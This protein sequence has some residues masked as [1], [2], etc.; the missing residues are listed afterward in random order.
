MAVLLWL[1]WLV[2]TDLIRPR[3]TFVPID[4]TLR[5][6]IVVHCC[7]CSD[8]GIHL[9]HSLFI[10]EYDCWYIDDTLSQVP[11][12][13]R[14]FDHHSECCPVLEATLFWLRCLCWWYD[15]HSLLTLWKYS[16]SILFF[17]CAWHCCILT[18]H[19]LWLTSHC[20]IL[21]YDVFV[22][23]SMLFST[24]DGDE[25][26]ILVILY[27]F[28]FQWPDGEAIVMQWPL[29]KLMQAHLS[30]IH[31]VVVLLW[32]SWHSERVLYSDSVF[33]WPLYLFNIV[34]DCIRCIRYS[35]H[36]SVFDILMMRLIR[37]DD[38]RYSMMTIDIIRYIRWLSMV[39]VYILT[40]MHC[41]DW[42]IVTFIDAAADLFTVS[43]H[44]LCDC[45][46]W[47]H[48]LTVTRYH[49]LIF[50]WPDF[51]VP[52]D[53]VQLMLTIVGSV[54]LFPFE[55]FIHS[56]GIHWCWWRGD[57]FLHWHCS[58]LYLFSDGDW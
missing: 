34:T 7:C 12:H 16:I 24:G 2:L 44:S 31:S 45:L 38:I 21:W 33:W 56:V 18:V 47:L 17:I 37:I 58:I 29:L 15:I 39:F 49:T 36:Y 4:A 51:D 14:S 11:K 50:K 8:H 57:L 35:C 28:P 41:S 27:S 9:F 43:L 13:G 22:V 53:D 52:V 1:K 23:H 3:A 42:F 40:T 46:W 5:Y 19:L 26:P 25:W 10:S 32:L 20:C 55:P 6:F 48:I 54:D 30:L